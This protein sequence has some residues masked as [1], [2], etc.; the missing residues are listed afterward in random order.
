[1]A[2]LRN[3]SDALTRRQNAWDGYFV[4]EHSTRFSLTKFS[5]QFSRSYIYEH[6]L[7]TSDYKNIE[8]ILSLSFILYTHFKH[9]TLKSINKIIDNEY[10]FCKL[11]R[12]N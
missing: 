3:E 5:K 9:F 10:T 1:M 7:G 2:D 4:Y 8:H 11:E 12:I 6:N